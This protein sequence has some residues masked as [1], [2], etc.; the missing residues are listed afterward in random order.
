MQ[1]SHNKTSMQKRTARGRR[2][3]ERVRSLD[4]YRYP[5]QYSSSS[6]EHAEQQYMARDGLWGA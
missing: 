3:W 6:K 5:P 1:L 4:F 2:L